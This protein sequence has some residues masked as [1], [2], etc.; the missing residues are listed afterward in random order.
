MGIKQLPTV[1]NMILGKRALIFG[2]SGQ[3]GAY[4]ARLL[5]SKGYQVWGASRDVQ[6]TSFTGLQALGIQDLVNLVSVS[7]LDPVSIQNIIRKISPHEIYN[8]MG[9]SSVGLSFT[10]PVE[11]SQSI[12]IGTL[13]ILEAIRVID[14]LIRFFHAGSSEAFGEHGEISVDESTPFKPCNP[15]A[16]A[17]AS[18]TWLVN[19]YRVSYGLFACTG[20][21]FNHES[22]LRPN[23]FVT[24]KITQT[25]ARIKLGLDA[26]LYLG[27]L[28][29]KKDWGHASDYVLAEWKMLQQ[30]E[31]ED[32][33]IATGVQRSVRAFVNE[34]AKT[35][36]MKLVWRG[37]GMDEKAYWSIAKNNAVVAV[38]PEYFRLVEVEAMQ[39]NP[40]KLN[41]TLGRLPKESF[42]NLVV[43]MLEEDMK[44]AMHEV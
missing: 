14:P 25:L 26:C 19:S 7:P 40:S 35:L 28:D 44:L 41:L 29:I 10:Q 34:T 21:L 12:I 9:Q 5:I 2:V 30:K 11:T 24:R 39:A 23:T 16:V 6:A 36:G 1:S 27:N 43:E 22:P 38:S 15:Y 20:I 8:F 33:V 32:Y 37:Q 3:D 4:L 13:N 31:P 42:K 18:A 17:K